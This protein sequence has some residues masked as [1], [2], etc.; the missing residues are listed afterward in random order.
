[1]T[2]YI[3]FTYY[4][5]SDIIRMQK[6][7]K[8]E[9]II[10]I[11]SEKIAKQLLEKYGQKL[12]TSDYHYRINYEYYELQER[13]LKKKLFKEE[14]NNISV[15]IPLNSIILR[16]EESKCE[17][18]KTN[19]DI[20]PTYSD[21]VDEII[22]KINSTELSIIY[23]NGSL[24]LIDENMEEVMTTDEAIS[25]LIMGDEDTLKKIKH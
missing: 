17:V 21:I 5:D 2:D 19:V 18:F 1:M 7:K 25:G 11:Q 20:Y 22:G 23:H 6:E 14:D 3:N 13:V 4:T 16:L 9:Y 8:K 12:L 10:L 24:Y 15:K